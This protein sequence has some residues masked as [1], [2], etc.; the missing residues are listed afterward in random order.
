MSVAALNV[1]LSLSSAKFQEG[2]AKAKAA[3]T[4]FEKSAKRIGKDFEKFGK[5]LNKVGSS[6]SSNL[7]LPILAA[8]AALGVAL[9]KTAD[10]GD[11]LVNMSN[12]TGASLKM[13]QELKFQGSQVGVTMDDIQSSLMKLSKSMGDAATGT[14]ASKEAF[15]MLGISLR[16]SNGNLKTSS[17]MFKEVVGQLG[18]VKDETAR[19]AIGIDLFGKGFTGIIPIIQE[20]KEGLSKYADEAAKAGL[21]MSDDA[22]IGADEFGDAMDKLKQR[23]E[24]AGMQIATAFMPIVQ[25]MASFIETSVLPAV[26]ALADW[27]KNLSPSMQG[28]II[29]VTAL[30][31][32]L[33]P[34]LMLFGSI[35]TGLGSIIT[36]APKVAAAF[37]TMAGP[38]GI[39]TVALAGI[40]ALLLWQPNAGVDNVSKQFTEQSAVVSN[41]QKQYDDLS[42]KVGETG[43]QYGSLAELM[44][45]GPQT[46]SENEIALQKLGAALDN[47]KKLLNELKAEMGPVIDSKK[48]MAAETQKINKEEKELKINLG[49]VAETFNSYN[50]VMGMTSQQIA[51]LRNHVG[52]LTP[53]FNAGSQS[54][55]AVGNEL[56]VAGEKAIGAG[57]KVG[58][59][60]TSFAGSIGLIQEKVAEFVVDTGAL[61]ADGID[62]MTTGI[63]N[64]MTESASISSVFDN[65]MLAIVNWGLQVSKAMIAA[66]IASQAFQKAILANPAVAL[67]AGVALAITLKI[68]KSSLEADMGGGQAFAQGGLVFGETLGLVGEGRGTSKSNPEVIA[69]LDKLLSFLQPQGGQGGQFEFII[70]GENLRAVQQRNQK[71]RQF[72]SG[73]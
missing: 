41:L 1:D 43:K 55:M 34:A 52:L 70:S 36:M 10:Y 64:F 26:R 33:G 61:F 13:L 16:D 23:F 56:F 71:F 8:G 69:P 62:V 14:K 27:F 28:V 15:A 19:N 29:G 67:A 45:A 44:A 66:A 68:V 48:M 17:D 21:I 50:G 72:G 20:G 32:A 4:D 30:V 6:L 58:S 12:R 11:E 47:E 38:L 7:T 24:A 57:I 73:Q 35:S 63:A 22:V 42:K 2:M 18:R 49:G 37:T 60:A 51:N 59:F 39:I 53:A 3:L 31:A 25:K 9:K 5:S 40:T 54:I 46:I 65:I